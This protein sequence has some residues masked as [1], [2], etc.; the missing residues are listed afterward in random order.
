MATR[1]PLVNVSGTIQELPTG[2]VLTGLDLASP[3]AIGGTTPAA[4]AFTTLS[5]SSTV[6]GTGFSSFLTS[7]AIGSSVQAYDADLD[8]WA[9]KTAPS[10]TVVGTSDTQTLSAKTLTG[11]KET[12]FTITDAAG[13]EIN[14]A[15]GGIQKVT[16]AATRTPVATDFTE[17][18]SV[19]LRVSTSSTYTITW[20]SVSPTWVSATDAAGSAPTLSTSRSTLIE[21]WKDGTTIYAALVGYA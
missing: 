7:S 16:L 10:G 13:F 19:L 2:D 12:V 14:P 15:N 20:S 11:T 18:Q 4:G 3:P 21:L 5:A 17:G 9:T 1:R 6:S 8:T